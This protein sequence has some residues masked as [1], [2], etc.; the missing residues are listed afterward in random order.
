MLL[1]NV[2]AVQ[3]PNRSFSLVESGKYWWW[4]TWHRTKRLGK[5]KGHYIMFNISLVLRYN[6]SHISKNQQRWFEA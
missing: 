5:G 4:L 6:L 1:V 2:N 3:L